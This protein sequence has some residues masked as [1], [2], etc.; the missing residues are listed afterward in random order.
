M[1]IRIEQAKKGPLYHIYTPQG[2]AFSISAKGIY[3]TGLS[4]QKEIDIQM[5]EAAR[6]YA[7]KEKVFNRAVYFLGFRDYSAGEMLDKLARDGMD[8]ADAVARL[9]QLGYIDDDKYA[10]RVLEKYKGRYGRRRIDEEL[11]RRKIDKEVR[12][13]KMSA[14]FDVPEDLCV[15]IAQKMNGQ[16]FEDKK[17]RDKVYA[18][19]VRR[20]YEYDDIK[21]AFSLYNESI[22]GM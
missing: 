21:K 11:R 8:G 7:E 13:Q 12:A 5:L 2:F 15:Q 9:K 10:D 16:P 18:Y 3:E 19:F 6:I 4:E 20:G 17:Q 1:R 22:E 14:F